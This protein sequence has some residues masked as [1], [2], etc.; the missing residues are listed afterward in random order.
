MRPSLPDVLTPVTVAVCVWVAAASTCL[1]AGT[2]PAVGAALFVA[3]D[4]SIWRRRGKPWHDPLVITLLLPALACGLWIGIGGEVV[5]I[6]RDATARLT[7][8]V[9]PGL[10]LTGLICT[11]ISYYGRHRP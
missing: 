9:G 10:A 6:D 1:S 7:L 5:G 11:L 2:A 8:E 4:Y 3:A